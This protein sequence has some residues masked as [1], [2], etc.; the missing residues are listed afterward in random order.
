VSC[1]HGTEIQ[2]PRDAEPQ[3]EEAIRAELDRELNHLTDATDARFGFVDRN[4][5]SD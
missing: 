1:S 5:P 3:E 2:V 4:R